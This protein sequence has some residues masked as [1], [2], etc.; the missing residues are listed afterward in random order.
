MDSLKTY[1]LELSARVKLETFCIISGKRIQ[2]K[3]TI[4]EFVDEIWKQAKLLCKHQPLHLKQSSNIS[5]TLQVNSIEDNALIL[6]NL[7]IIVSLSKMLFKVII[8]TTAMQNSIPPLFR[9][10]EE[11]LTLCRN[12][13]ILC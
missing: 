1:L 13:S 5:R 3:N 9:K 6:L 7:K 11:N 2:L 10:K 12:R 4:E 8:G